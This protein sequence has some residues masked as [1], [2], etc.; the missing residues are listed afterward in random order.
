MYYPQTKTDNKILANFKDIRNK[1]LFKLN[2][3]IYIK[4]SNS[5]YPRISTSNNRGKRSA[6]EIINDLCLGLI[7]NPP[8]EII[9][10]IMKDVTI[11]CDHDNGL[12][13]SDDLLSFI[14][15]EPK[16]VLLN[17]TN[18]LNDILYQIK[19]ANFNG[20]ELTQISKFVC[21]LPIGRN[22]H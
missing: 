7:Y 3:G 18:K 20:D 22:W 8:F 16:K 6:L 12:Y 15:L 9:F 4:K 2:Q 14:N 21:S 19:Q 11:S 13:Y 5:I 1:Y 10:D 17:P